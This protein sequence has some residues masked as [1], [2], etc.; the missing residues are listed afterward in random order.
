MLE[1]GIGKQKCEGKE[2]KGSKTKHIP[3]RDACVLA[4]L[5]KCKV[6]ENVKT[7]T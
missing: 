4:K 6:S 1:E 3:L 2:E 5:Q 7:R